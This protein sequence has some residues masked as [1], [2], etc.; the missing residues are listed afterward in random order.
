M[1]SRHRTCRS[2]NSIS[3]VSVM[4]IY[5]DIVGNLHAP[6]W[7]E[8]ASKCRVRYIVLDQWTAQKSRLAASDDEGNECAVSL[9]RNTRLQDGDVL[10]Y[11][12]REGTLLAVRV[13]LN[14]VLV[15][16]LSALR[17]ESVEKAV[18]TALELGHAIGN[19][20]WPAVMKG[21]R[22]Y[23]PLTVDRKVMRS[24]MQT[25]H[26]EGV[27]YDFCRGSEVIP[28]L[29]PHE[30]RRLFGGAGRD[31]EHA[32]VHAHSHEDEHLHEHEHKNLHA[33]SHEDEHEHEHIRSHEHAH[34]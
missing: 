7:R 27:T 13:E 9:P 26:I 12:E 29:A 34:I 15:A 20:H 10:A 17:E 30:I 19:Q 24:V 32:H 14:D 21:L 28:Y 3:S 33:H 16:D 31:G 5:T 18:R 6:E 23:I 22:V 8:R 2:L 1:L 11:D 4:N 25:H